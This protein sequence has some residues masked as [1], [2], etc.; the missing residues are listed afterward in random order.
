MVTKPK[1]IRAHIVLLAQLEGL[2][3]RVESDNHDM[4]ATALRLLEVDVQMQRLAYAALETLPE[5]LYHV[6][7]E[8]EYLTLV[9]LRARAH[10]VWLGHRPRR[11]A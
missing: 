6:K 8:P 9:Y 7:Y 3:C 10:E 1:R 11:N 4:D 2:C 5:S